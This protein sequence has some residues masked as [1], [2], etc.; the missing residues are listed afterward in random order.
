MSDSNGNAYISS[1]GVECEALAA[2]VVVACVG[3]RG[4]HGRAVQV[5]PIKPT[6]KAP[7]L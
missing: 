7:E 5:D 1:R 6:L 2:G 3:G 4:R